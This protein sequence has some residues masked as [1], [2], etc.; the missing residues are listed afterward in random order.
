MGSGIAQVAATTGNSVTVV[1]VDSSVLQ[2]TQLIV[3]KSLERVA[4]KKFADDQAVC[5]NY[6]WKIFEKI[7]FFLIKHHIVLKV[8]LMW[9]LKLNY[10]PY[11]TSWTIGK[12]E[13]CQSFS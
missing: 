7:M 8:N 4:K 2:K 6:Y 13:V 1:D 12:F 3:K 9:T 5:V 11:S 10:R